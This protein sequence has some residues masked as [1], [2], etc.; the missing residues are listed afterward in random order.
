MFYSDLPAE[1]ADAAFASLCKFHSHKSLST[2]PTFLESDITVPKL[3]LL[4]EKDQTLAPA[5]QEAMVQVGK[6]DR[7][8]RLDSGHS[9]FLSI[10]EEVV[11]AIVSFSGEVAGP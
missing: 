6:F 11:E 2:A 7:V 10:P 9:P 8:I 3:Y 5:F 1:K 4:C